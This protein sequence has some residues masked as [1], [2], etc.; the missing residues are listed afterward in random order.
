MILLDTS[1]AILLL[2]GVEPPAEVAEESFGISTIVELELQLG[3]LHG[4]GR[5]EHRRVEEFLARAEVHPFDREA[6]SE[7]ARVMA[8]LWRRGKPIGDLDAQIA[9]H[10]LAL[11]LRLLTSNTRHFERVENLRVIAWKARRRR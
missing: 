3:V 6:A 2:R 7:T 4:G 1:A 8:E 5:K 10:A 9:G 11:G